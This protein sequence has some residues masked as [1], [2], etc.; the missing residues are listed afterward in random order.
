VAVRGVVGCLLNAVEGKGREENKI[1][2]ME[3][4]G[5]LENLEVSKQ[6]EKK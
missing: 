1:R 2:Q 5:V 3:E 4:I 6:I